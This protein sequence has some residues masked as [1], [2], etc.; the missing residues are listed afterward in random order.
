MRAA[1][2]I[3]KVMEEVLEDIW[4]DILTFNFLHVKFK[5]KLNYD[6]SIK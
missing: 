6:F 1:L 2:E 4:S 5:L 3:P